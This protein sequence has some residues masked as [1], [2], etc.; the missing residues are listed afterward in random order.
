MAEAARTV[1]HRNVCLL[2]R[3][4]SSLM[5]APLS[6]DAVSAALCRMFLFVVTHQHSQCKVQRLVYFSMFPFCPVGGRRWEAH[7]ST[8][9]GQICFACFNDIS[10][11]LLNSLLQ[12]LHPTD[13]LRKHWR[14]S[15]GCLLWCHL[16]CVHMS[17]V[18][19]W[20]YG[21][22][23]NTVIVGCTVFGDLHLLLR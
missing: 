11:V 9:C 21:C 20:T 8:S 3:S 1:R 18:R 7:P 22:S 17:G 5:V 6:R 13:H 4:S 14:F 12:A 19:H 15:F 10:L 23:A 16:V 2:L